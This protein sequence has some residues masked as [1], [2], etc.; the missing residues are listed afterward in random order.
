MSVR[1]AGGYKWFVPDFRFRNLPLEDWE[2]PERDW[3]RANI[4][5]GG[6]F[7]DIGANSGAYC[8][9][10]ADHFE[11]VYAIEPAT[12]NIQVLKENARLNG[13][14]NLIILQQAAW[15]DW[16]TLRYHQVM[17]G[18]VSSGALAC[19]GPYPYGLIPVSTTE[20]KAAPIDDL[21]I[22]PSVVKIDVEG[23]EIHVLLGMVR[24]ISRCRPVILVELHEERFIEFTKILMD[25]LGYR[26]ENPENAKRL[27]VLIFRPKKG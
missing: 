6:V 4:P 19:D 27:R 13:V 25:V 16:K 14:E 8:I 17:E 1:E 26:L 21:D 11:T 18:D 9:P 7:L 3:I 15:S 22:G 10:L 5:K 23:G 12:D 24:T 20:V 2:R